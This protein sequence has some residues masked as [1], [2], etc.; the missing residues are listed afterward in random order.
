MYD[1]KKAGVYSEYVNKN[2]GKKEELFI[3]I[4][5]RKILIVL[6]VFKRQ[7]EIKGKQRE[8]LGYLI[9]RSSMIN[10]SLCNLNYKVN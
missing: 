6:H 5:F 8:Y 4:C 7:H 3:F 10:D 2:V 9:F 1:L